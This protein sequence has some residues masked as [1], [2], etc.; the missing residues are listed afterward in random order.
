MDRMQ[1]YM[2]GYWARY[3]MCAQKPDRHPWHARL[4]N[5]QIQLLLRQRSS[6]LFGG[7]GK[8][9]FLAALAIVH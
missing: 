9:L 3:S 1:Q 8:N 6:L 2:S 7:G 5:A 4:I